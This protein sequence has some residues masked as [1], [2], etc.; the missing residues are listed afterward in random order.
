MEMSHEKQMPR[1]TPSPTPSA[2]VVQILSPFRR[3]LHALPRR[4]ANSSAAKTARRKMG[5]VVYLNAAR[6][7]ITADEGGSHG[8]RNDLWKW[9]LQQL[10]DA[11]GLEISV[12]RFPPGTSNCNKVE[13]DVSAT[14]PKPGVAGSLAAASSW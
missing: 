8:A 14:S 5:V 1:R 11:S 3:F 13:L 6:L 4:G 2:T 9:S 10:P 7:S 12:C